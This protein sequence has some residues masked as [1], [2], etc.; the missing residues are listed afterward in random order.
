MNRT[1]ILF[2]VMGLL[3]S[4]SV[5]AE[6]FIQGPTLYNETC[7][8]RAYGDIK[9]ISVSGS[10]VAVATQ[11]DCNANFPVNC[12]GLFVFDINVKN[13]SN[14]P[15]PYVYGT[16]G[17][18]ES[19]HVD[20][21][22]LA[23]GSTE[24]KIYYLE[25][26]EYKKW[27]KVWDKTLQGNVLSVRIS[28][29]YVA[30]AGGNYVYLFDTKGNEKWKYN[31]NSKVTV[32]TIADDKVI[33]GA[34]DGYVYIFDLAGNVIKSYKTGASVESVY[35]ED[36]TIAVGS[37][38]VYVFDTGGVLTW[39]SETKGTIKSV[40]FSN[41]T[42][43]AGS[44]GGKIYV[45]DIK[46]KGKIKTEYIADS[47][48]WSVHVAGE[49][50]AAGATDGTTYVIGSDGDFKWKYKVDK[51]ALVRSGGVTSVYNTED[52]VY[53]GG[54]GKNLYLFNSG[55]PI[56]EDEIKTAE[57]LVKTVKAVMDVSEANEAIQKARN[58]L[59]SSNYVRS[60]EYSRSVKPIITKDVQDLIAEE[61]RILDAIAKT[62]DIRKHG[63]LSNVLREANVSLEEAKTRVDIEEAKKL[64]E[65]EK[66]VD[67]VKKANQTKVSVD[68]EIKKIIENVR[69][70][71]ISVADLRGPKL[72]SILAQESICS[73]MSKEESEAELELVGEIQVEFPE[74]SE[75]IR[76][77]EEAFNKSDYEHAIRYSEA[78]I[79]NIETKVNEIIKDS[80]NEIKKVGETPLIF[81]ID[82][83]F[84][85]EEITT[86][87]NRLKYAKCGAKEESDCPDYAAAAIFWSEH[88]KGVVNKDKTI[89]IAQNISVLLLV[90]V[91]AIFVFNH[92]RGKKKEKEEEEEGEES[93]KEKS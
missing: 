48:V 44:L 89:T 93:G 9:E 56:A 53:T 14:V 63:A 59:N 26:N 45:Y 80:E 49:Y 70:T 43:V 3:L 1:F 92:F 69:K 86:A 64:V 83:S 12:N 88:A 7:N 18:I 39:K 31:V 84:A 24:N 38:Q 11:C 27:Q 15:E 37:D 65:K 32:V 19:V 62:A 68:A 50:I 57:E 90:V 28:G 16:K 76:L 66:Y 61:E 82:T 17:W 8:A 13:T 87:R 23:F 34:S 6:V 78:A 20:K 67:S 25:V 75:S 41:G 5:S 30:S 55:K 72:E 47:P 85:L 2:V 22:R 4:Y 29:S 58:D 42:L 81:K 40:H 79:G 91:I 33:A 21:N 60:V 52:Y 77:A 74:S 73:V 35:A 36:K 71:I 54:W 51:G 46:G 10:Y